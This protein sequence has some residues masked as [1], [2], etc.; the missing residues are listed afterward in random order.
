MF[1]AGANFALQYKIIVQRKFDALLRSDEFKAYLFTTLLITFGVALGLI[2]EGRYLKLDALRDGLFATISFM[3]T[4]GFAAVDYTEW[5]PVAKIILFLA[6]F[7]GACAGSAA[8]GPKIVRLLYIGKYIKTEIVKILHPNAVLP[9]KIDKKIIPEDIGKQIVS[10]LIFY[11]LL[12]AVIAFVVSLIEKN[13]ITG[14]T[15]SIATLGNIGPA[16]GVLGPLGSFAVLQPAT[17]F[18]FIIAMLVGR[19]ELIPFLAM[20]HKDFWKIK[21]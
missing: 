12:F 2:F 18:I 6:M 17:K 3:T 11:F 21:S 20:F 9:I 4:S 1:L 8:G 10:F 13:T 15:G 14:L 5:V 7:T 19:L 16:F